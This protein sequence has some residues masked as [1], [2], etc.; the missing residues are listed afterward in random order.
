M[1]LHI[2]I[3]Q[4]IDDDKKFKTILSKFIAKYENYFQKYIL[5]K[6]ISEAGKKHVHM[7]VRCDD[8]SEKLCNSIRMYI[9]RQMN[10]QKIT[11]KGGICSVVKVKTDYMTILRYITKDGEILYSKNVSPLD[12]IECKTYVTK[13][14]SRKKIDIVQDV[15]DKLSQSFSYQQM[16]K[17][18]LIENIVDMVIE[19]MLKNDRLLETML[20]K[21]YTT[22]I[23]VK[24]RNDYS[25][26][27]RAVLCQI[28]I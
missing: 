22:T 15:L 12:L 18:D 4:L 26:L 2:R 20:I 5:V 17:N 28:K 7:Y 6:E 11:Y 24:Y 14:K 27:K 9:H 23:Y 19:A 13:T 21:K 10:P 3:D 25:D 16:C 8:S 1:E